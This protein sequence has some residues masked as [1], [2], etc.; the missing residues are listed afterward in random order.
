[1]LAVFV[2]TEKLSNLSTSTMG[3]QQLHF[4]KEDEIWNMCPMESVVKHASHC[5]TTAA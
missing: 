5:D 4:S 2:Q 1:M 3:K